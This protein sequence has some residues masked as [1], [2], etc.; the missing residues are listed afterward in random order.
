MI[1]RYKIIS[2][3]Y[4]GKGKT[5]AERLRKRIETVSEKERYPLAT[6]LIL[7]AVLTG[8]L[9]SQVMDLF[10]ESEF[11]IAFLTAEDVCVSDDKKHYRL[12]QNV[13]FEIGMAL[14]ELGRERCILLSDRDWSKEELELPSDMMSLNVLSFDPEK[15]DAVMDDVLNKILRES[16]TSL[17]TGV[18]EE[19]IPQYDSLFTRTDYFVHYESLF[20]D[21]AAY[22]MY[23]GRE[24]LGAVLQ[25]WDQ[26]CAALPHYDEQCIYLME[27]L[28]FMPF[29]GNI[30]EAEQLLAHAW[31]WAQSYK[32]WD[33]QYYKKKTELLGFVRMVILN[34]VEYTQLKQ[35]HGQDQMAEY[36]RLLKRFLEFPVSR[37]QHINPLIRVVYYDYLGLTYLRLSAYQNEAEYVKLAQE[38]FELALN[39]A[40]K[41]DTSMSVW[42]GFLYHNLARTYS[43]QNEWEKARIAFDKAISIRG[44]WIRNTAFNITIRN[45]L[46][47]EY[48]VA[49]IAKFEMLEK[50]NRM[51]EDEK[52]RAID[53]LET[54]LN[55]YHDSGKEVGALERIRVFISEHKKGLPD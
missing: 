3:I 9:L 54:E 48:F 52:R 16:T 27:R 45:A 6:R 11:C 7:E 5:Y 30:R 55:T 4:G 22:G 49:K 39:Y 50:S 40:K 23:S 8:E 10:R 20:G 1:S 15:F 13:V 32:Q 43:R 44:Q 51:S 34:V 2:I 21:R 53:N 46:S 17:R 47:Y 41:V 28:G 31:R 36:N 19:E 25:D 24:L 38:N 29:F 42:A 33:I 37:K 12:R 14:M 26:E 35:Y 18:S